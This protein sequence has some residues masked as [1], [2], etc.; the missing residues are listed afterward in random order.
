MKKRTFVIA[1][2]AVATLLAGTAIAS[3]SGS[4]YCDRYAARQMANI[5][6]AVLSQWLP[7]SEVV[8]RLSAQGYESVTRMQVRHGLYMVKASDKEGRRQDL[9]VNPITGD[10]IG[11]KRD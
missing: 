1:G 10:V 7:A 11:F 6:P 2:A 5:D 4:G 8:S 3:A 9:Q